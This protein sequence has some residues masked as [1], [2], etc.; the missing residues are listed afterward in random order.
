MFDPRLP[1]FLPLFDPRLFEPR[2]FDPRLPE[3]LPL[4]EPLLGPFDPLLDPLFDPLKP[5]ILRFDVGL[6]WFFDPALVGTLMW[7]FL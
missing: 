5:L 7:L 3:F 4:F 6:P 2:L 1:E